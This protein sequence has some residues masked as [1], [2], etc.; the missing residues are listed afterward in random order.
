MSGFDGSLARKLD[1]GEQP[2]VISSTGARGRAGLRLASVGRLTGPDKYRVLDRRRRRAQIAARRMLDLFD[3]PV[4][5][6]KL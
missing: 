4:R 1:F 6:A 5:P 2:T 3:A